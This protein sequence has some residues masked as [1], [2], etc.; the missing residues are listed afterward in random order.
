MKILIVEDNAIISMELKSTLVSAGF[1]VI[2]IAKSSQKALE[3]AEKDPP[4]AVL[5]DV[6]IK[7]DVNGVQTASLLNERMGF[8]LFYLTGNNTLKGNQDA[9]NT[10]PKAFISKPINSQYLINVL[11]DI[12]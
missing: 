3:L 2:G 4:D 6:D 11:K 10:N 5:M 7:G 8:A 1:E 9:L 12:S